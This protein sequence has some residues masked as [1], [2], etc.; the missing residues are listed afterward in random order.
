MPPLALANHFT[1]P[2]LAAA[3]RVSV[4]LLQRDA[5]VVLVI[6]GDAVTV[7]VVVGLAEHPG[8][9]TATVYVPLALAP[10]AAMVGF[11]TSELKELGP[12]HEKVK[13]PFPPLVTTPSC[14]LLPE[15]SG[16]LLVAVKL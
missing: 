5:G 13:G 4:P 7:A 11:C 16:L 14:R 10:A 2:A 9:V 6:V 3:T 12:V 1:E 8:A 15:Q